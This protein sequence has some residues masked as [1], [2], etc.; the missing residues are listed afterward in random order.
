MSSTLIRLPMHT[1]LE[2]KDIAF[3]TQAG[4]SLKLSMY[5]PFDK[6]WREPLME[7]VLLKDLRRTAAYALQNRGALSGG[8]EA[9]LAPVDSLL[10]DTQTFRYEGEGLALFSDGEKTLAVLLPKAPAPSA[11]I[12]F[13]FRLDGVLTQVFA[14]DRFYLLSLSQHAVKLWDCDGVSLHPISLEGL[15]TDI[16]K[17]PHF[18]EAEYQAVVHSGNASGHGQS[19]SHAG[20]GVADGRKLKKEIEVFFRAIDHGIQSRILAKKQPMVLAGVGFLLPIYRAVNTYAGLLAADLPGNSEALGTPE[21]LHQRAYALLQAAEI[22]ERNQAL[23][24]FIE[25][26]TRARSCAGYTDLV[27]CAAQGRL[28]HLFVARGVLQ[29]GD[30]EQ[31]TGRTVLFD[32]YRDG[33]VDLGNVACVGAIRTHAKAYAVPAG[34]MPAGSQIAGLYRE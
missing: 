7:K 8:I 31:A 30:F 12:D 16:R 24:T 2:E 23:G 26:L 22:Q 5:F 13:R 34:E 29:W 1:R 20:I 11:E 21:D 14:R 9:I 18:Q 33:A 19:S 25:N 15:E 28:S 6:T 10:A 17:T 3:L 32:T 27:P 4:S